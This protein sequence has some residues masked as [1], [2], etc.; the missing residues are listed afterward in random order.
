MLVCRTIMCLSCVNEY[1][2]LTYF[3]TNDHILQWRQLA[4]HAMQTAYFCR[5]K[6]Y[7][8]TKNLSY[9]RLIHIVV[10]IAS[11]NR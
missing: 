2:L 11:S 1:Y 3:I 9:P 6:L 5:P 7:S 10:V 8:H 4:M